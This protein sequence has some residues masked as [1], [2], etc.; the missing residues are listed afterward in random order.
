MEYL[1]YSPDG[2]TGGT[3]HDGGDGLGVCLFLNGRGYFAV[4]PDGNSQ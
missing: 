3:I 1:A 2:M 4:S